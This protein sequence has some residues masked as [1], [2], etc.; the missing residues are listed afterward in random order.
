M[1]EL[2]CH[3]ALLNSGLE[4]INLVT[5]LIFLGGSALNSTSISGW[6]RSIPDYFLKVGV[7][8]TNVNQHRT[9]VHG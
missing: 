8:G 2:C 3:L 4:Y 9:V 1:L 7:S 5:D 6:V